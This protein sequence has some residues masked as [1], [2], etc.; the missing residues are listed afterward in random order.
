MKI[1]DD[2]KPKNTSK[3]EEL[4]MCVNIYIQPVEIGLK[5]A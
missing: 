5:S 4:Y 2:I 3:T 1:E